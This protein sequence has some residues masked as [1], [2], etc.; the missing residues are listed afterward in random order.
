MGQVLAENSITIG[1]HLAEDL[2][3]VSADR[4]R[5]LQV[6]LNLISNAVKFCN[7]DAGRIDIS[8]IKVPGALR[9]AVADNGAGI[10]HEAQEMIFEKFRQ[11]GDTLTEKP[12]GSGLGLAISR[13]I[14]IH[15]GGR[16]GV[17]S[18]PGKGATSFFTVPLSSVLN[19]ETHYAQAQRNA[20]SA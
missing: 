7:R 13:Q 5:L 6:L 15:L 19:S 1:L 4:D 3:L 18:R 2:P 14:V 10:E 8:L 17:E 16:L 20:A 12:Q 9:V 11:A